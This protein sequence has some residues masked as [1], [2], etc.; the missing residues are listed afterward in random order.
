MIAHLIDNTLN[1]RLV[2]G[3][4]VQECAAANGRRFASDSFLQRPKQESTRPIRSAFGHW[5]RECFVA[6]DVLAILH[7]A[8][9]ILFLT[10]DDRAV[11]SA[12]GSEDGPRRAPDRA[13]RAA[14]RIVADGELGYQGFMQKEITNSPPF[15]TSHG[16]EKCIARPLLAAGGQDI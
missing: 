7:H 8:R 12:G 10:D 3:R 13:P 6:S 1:G 14:R 11:L 5:T 4:S 9:D 16:K 2:K 15:R